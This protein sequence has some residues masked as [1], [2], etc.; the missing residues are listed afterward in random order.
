MLVKMSANSSQESRK[1]QH[2][3]P[4][5]QSIKVLKSSEPLAALSARIQSSGRGDDASLGDVPTLLA[6]VGDHGNGQPET[7]RRKGGRKKVFK[8]QRVVQPSV[9]VVKLSPE[10]VG[11][12]HS[13]LGVEGVICDDHG[14]L[15]VVPILHPHRYDKDMYAILQCRNNTGQET[16][17]GSEV[18]CVF[19]GAL[20]CQL[21]GYL[22]LGGVFRDGGHSVHV[23]LTL[24]KSEAVTWQ[25][26]IEVG[27]GVWYLPIK[28]DPLLDNV[29]VE[30]L[31]K[32]L[33]GM[34]P[35]VKLFLPHDSSCGATN[36]LPLE[37]WATD[38]ICNSSFAS[39]SNRSR[40]MPLVQR[41]KRGM[42]MALD[43]LVKTLHPS[44]SEEE[45]KED[46]VRS[47]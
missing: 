37:F 31:E 26:R 18:G 9:P 1:R 2:P 8:V 23:V 34:M 24:H 36:S 22:D 42:E 15:V 44:Y 17:P 14:S 6:G 7:R 12:I 39:D 38:K 46:S 35:L 30:D 11:S 19:I 4:E 20:T 41:K 40:N 10:V 13:V 47:L 27:K 29:S 5:D 3:E 25:V 21:E 45:Q 43:Q 33:L 28:M 16:S 32:M